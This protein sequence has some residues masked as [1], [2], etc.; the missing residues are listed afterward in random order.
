MLVVLLSVSVDAQ[1]AKNLSLDYEKDRDFTKKGN[2]IFVESKSDYQKQK[3][4]D[5]E[6]QIEGIK[7]DL[8]KIKQ[9]MNDIK[10]AFDSLLLRLESVQ[11]K[12]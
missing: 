7:N 2:I 1:P 12:R 5:I 8:S 4:N 6:N 10:K 11:N 9:E 3:I